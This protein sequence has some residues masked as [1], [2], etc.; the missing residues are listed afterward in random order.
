MHCFRNLFMHLLLF[1]HIKLTY[2]LHLGGTFQTIM[3]FSVYTALLCVMKSALSSAKLRV[4][5]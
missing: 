3:A 1:C 2:R 4:R 5:H